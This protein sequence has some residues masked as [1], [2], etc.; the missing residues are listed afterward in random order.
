VQKVKRIID[1]GVVGTPY[2]ATVET[3]WKRDAAYYETPWR[4]HWRTEL[5][6]VLLTHAIHAHDLMTWLLGPPASVF[7]RTATRVNPIQTE[8]CA[9]AALVMQNGALVSLAATL[10]SEREITRLRLCFEHATFESG[11]KPYAPGDDPWVI[12]AASPEAEQRIS[13]VLAGYRPVSPRFGGLFGAYHAALATDSPL[14]VTLA[15]ARLSIELATALYH[16]AA[17]GAP[18]ALPI[19]PDH[20]AYHGWRALAG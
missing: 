1:S 14:P 8:D 2:L 13:E 9:V 6:G 7:A 5:G 16:S 3:M 12:T 19:A 4:G 10:G 20:P 17:S 15:E 11:E 18:V